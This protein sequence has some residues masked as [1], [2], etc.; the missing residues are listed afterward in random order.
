MVDPQTVM[1]WLEK[2]EAVIIDVREPQEWAGAHIDGAQNNPLS[3]FD[4]AK[5]PTPEDKKVVLHCHSGVRCGMASEMLRLSGYT[6]P[7]HRMAGGLVAWHQAGGPLV[8]GA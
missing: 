4:P 2:G 1:E 7:L 3:A 8:Q 5:V 6:S